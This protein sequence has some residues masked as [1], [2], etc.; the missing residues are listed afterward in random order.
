[1]QPIGGALAIGAFAVLYPNA[2][3]LAGDI[4]NP[5]APHQTRPGDQT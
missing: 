1:M 2:A 4:A 5:D 3:R